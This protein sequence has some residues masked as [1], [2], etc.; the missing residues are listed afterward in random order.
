M[1]VQSSDNCELDAPL[2]PFRPIKGQT[3]RL[4]SVRDRLGLKSIADAPRQAL[5]LGLQRMEA[6]AEDQG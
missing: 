1:P 6:L 2:R 4:K 3:E 5:E